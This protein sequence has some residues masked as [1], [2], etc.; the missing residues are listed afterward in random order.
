MPLFY[1]LWRFYEDFRATPP[2]NDTVLLLWG[3]ALKSS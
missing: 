2:P 1:T 3:V